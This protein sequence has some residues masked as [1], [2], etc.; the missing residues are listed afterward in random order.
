MEPGG[1]KRKNGMKN[2]LT[3]A[4]NP[5]SQPSTLTHE[6]STNPARYCLRK[7]QGYWQLTFAGQDAVLKHEQGLAYVA[8]LLLNP[9]DEPIHA[10]AL[11]LRS[12]TTRDQTDAA[13]EIVDPA[14]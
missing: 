7:G 14:T 9:P 6:L 11:A 12:Q 4:G 2:T 8:Y 3:T 13:T 5:G 10:L 1:R